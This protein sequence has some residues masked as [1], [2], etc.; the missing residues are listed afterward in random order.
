MKTGGKGEKKLFKSSR[1]AWMWK[2]RI[3]NCQ[4]EYENF[5]IEHLLC[6]EKL[7][8]NNARRKKRPPRH[9]G[10]RAEKE[11]K[12]ITE[13]KS[14]IWWFKQIQQEN[15]RDKRMKRRGKRFNLA[16]QVWKSKI[17]QTIPSSSSFL[18]IFS[19][20]LC[21]SE[22]DGKERIWRLTVN[23]FCLL[24]KASIQIQYKLFFFGFD[25]FSFNSKENPICSI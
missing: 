7:C 12:P 15:S 8:F 2:T 23:N 3:K 24:K 14:L 22:L 20:E 18:N 25:E 6:P 21:Y 11:R 10:K 13:N 17:S 16:N 4:M 5:I 1:P 9:W 19:G